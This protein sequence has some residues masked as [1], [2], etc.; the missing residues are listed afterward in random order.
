MATTPGGSDA[1]SPIQPQADIGPTRKSVCRELDVTKRTRMIIF[2]TVSVSRAMRSVI[3]YWAS[4]CLT[5]GAMVYA[6][7]ES[8]LPT[9]ESTLT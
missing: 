1:T 6:R 5:L 7:C 9:Q 3:R 4:K 8:M 2:I